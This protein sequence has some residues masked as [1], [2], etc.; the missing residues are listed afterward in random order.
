MAEPPVEA[1]SALQS[2]LGKLGIQP[3]SPNF[4]GSH[5]LHN[6]IDVYRSHLAEILRPLINTDPQLIYDSLQWT[7]SLVHGDLVLVVPKL[8]LKGVKPTEYAKELEPKVCA[9]AS[10]GQSHSKVFLTDT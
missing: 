3:P 7:N 6:P 9:V 4:A 10:R 8:R 2:N 5:I 1:L